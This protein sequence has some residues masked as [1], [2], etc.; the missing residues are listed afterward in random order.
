MKK[1]L[2]T[3]ACILFASIA[4]SQ[5][6]VYVDTEYIL[7]KIP[8]YKEAQKQIDNLTK[9]WQTEIE[10]KHT[11][12][13]AMYKQY[14]VDKVLLSNDMKAKREQ[15]ILDKEKELKELQKKRFGEDGD[16]FKKEQEL[17]KPIQDEI[18]NAI[19]EIST[20]QGY[21]FVFDASSSSLSILYS[22]VKYDISD[23]VLKKLGYIK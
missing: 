4:F 5:K 10:E 19:K 22:D 15:E 3:L 12:L 23:E 2:F 11:A 13:D 6:T 16:R 8:S 9:Q 21:A 14:Q 7:N 1:T 18:F 20:A 17:I